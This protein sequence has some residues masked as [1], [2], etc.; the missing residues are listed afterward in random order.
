M[1]ETADAVVRIM[2]RMIAIKDEAIAAWI[3]FD[4][5][6]SD[7]MRTIAELGDLSREL[8]YTLHQNDPDGC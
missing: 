5:A 6:T 7:Q 4:N 2:D 1:D 8:Y 3:D